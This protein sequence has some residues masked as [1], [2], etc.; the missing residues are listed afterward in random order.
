MS[1]LSYFMLRGSPK[2]TEL[3][4]R[5]ARRRFDDRFF[6]VC[7]HP[8]ANPCGCRFF[9]VCV[10]PSANPCAR[11]AHGAELSFTHFAPCTYSLWP[12]QPHPPGGGR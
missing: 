4:N 3:Y 5:W 11:P 8:S 12:L 7:V 1:F 10:H 2:N 9:S 6:S